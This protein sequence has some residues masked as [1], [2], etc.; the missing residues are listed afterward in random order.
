MLRLT[1]RTE[2]P[3]ASVIQVEGRV[4]GEWVAL[5]EAECSRALTKGAAVKLDM[6]GVSD[7]DREG[8]TAL[9]RLQ[10]RDVT[11]IGC[12]PIMLAMLSEERLI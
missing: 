9:R 2:D 7:V 12:T 8:L 11:L 4:A 3:G 6:T 10:Q 1:L 5:L